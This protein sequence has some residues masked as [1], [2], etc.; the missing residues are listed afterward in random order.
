MS[1][2]KIFM[3]MNNGNLKG[4]KKFGNAFRGAYLIWQYLEDK[5]MPY[6]KLG[7]GME[8]EFSVFTTQEKDRLN[9]FW[10]LVN[11]DRLSIAEKITLYHTYDG[12][13]VKKK[14]FKK[15]IKAFEEVSN[16]ME[17]CGH[18][19]DQ[20]IAV[21]KLIHEPKVIGICWQHTSVNADA[22]LNEGWVYEYDEETGNEIDSRP[23]NIFKD[24][25]HDQYWLFERLNKR[26]KKNE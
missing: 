21:E 1:Y 12:V 2:M 8:R 22:W 14:N 24:N 11:D 19:K 20:I 16:Q 7:K 13:M 10:N 4:Y 26:M 15:L 18:L 6:N 3:I 17:D 5:Y 23:F 25:Y 9:K